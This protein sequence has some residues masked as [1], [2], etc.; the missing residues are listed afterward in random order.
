M[1]PTSISTACPVPDYRFNDKPNGPQVLAGRLVCYTLLMNA[2]ILFSHG[3]TLCGAGETLKT[4]A[5]NL[6]T[7]G[8][9][10]IVRVGF[11]NYSTPRFGETFDECVALGAT[12]I[13][14]VPYFLVAGYF[15][16]VEL[17][18]VLD[19]AQE[20]HPN[21]KVLIAEAMRDHHALEDAILACAAR[22]LPTDQWRDLIDTAPQWCEG[23]PQCPLFGTPECPKSEVPL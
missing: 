9:A 7:D 15:V 23:D 10:D 16:K 22:A 5:Q 12:Q 13:I 8:A 11:L 18:K 6:E 14:V 21:V 17:P 20:K 1:R 3:S 4:L 2:M 19:P